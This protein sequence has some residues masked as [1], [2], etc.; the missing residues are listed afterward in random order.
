MLKKHFIFLLSVLTSALFVFAQNKTKPKVLIIPFQSK[1]YVGLYDAPINKASK[2]SAAKIKF[3]FRKNTNAYLSD[4]LKANNQCTD[5]CSDTSKYK[6]D[7][8]YFYSNCGI[9]LVKINTTSNTKGPQKTN[10]SIKKG[11]LVN[12]SVNM[13]LYYTHSKPQSKEV[14]KAYDKRFKGEYF[15]SINQFD[16]VPDDMNETIKNENSNNRELKIHYS[17]FDLNGVHLYGDYASILVPKKENKPEIIA[18][19]YLKPLMTE[20]AADLNKAISKAKAKK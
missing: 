11:R 9:E 7:L 8:S 4:A 2:W 15:I 18:A 3:F 5:L 13:D 12:N 6:L 1:L 16:F 19:N 14:F 10:K 20:I 17:L